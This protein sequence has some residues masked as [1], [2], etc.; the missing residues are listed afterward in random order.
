MCPGSTQPLRNEYQVIPGGKGGRCVGLTTLVCR[1]SRNPRALTSRT[2]QGYVGL[3]RGYFAFYLL[4]L[5][6]PLGSRPA[7]CVG[8]R[9][10]V[11][12][13]ARMNGLEWGYSE[14]YLWRRRSTLGF[15]ETAERRR[16]NV[17]GWL[18]G[19]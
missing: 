16:E 6:L 3:F 2:P 14:W 8:N 12:M 17:A 7:G 19:M 10:V 9:L 5:K 18:V 1:L 13:L 15:V 11:T 4:E